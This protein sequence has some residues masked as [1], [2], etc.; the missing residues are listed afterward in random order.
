VTATISAPFTYD[1]AGT[2]CWRTNN[3]GRFVNSWNVQTLT[4]NGINF[5]GQYVAANAYPAQINGYWYIRYVS[6]I[7]QGHFE[8]LP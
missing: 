1:G 7:A 6:N 8:T 5:T 3:L 4:I 2:F